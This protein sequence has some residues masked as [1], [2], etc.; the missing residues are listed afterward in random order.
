M[1]DKQIFKVLLTF[2]VV[3]K[4][5]STAVTATT[6]GV[7]TTSGNSTTSTTTP[8]MT[9]PT[10]TNT[11][12]NTTTPTTTTPVIMASNTAVSATTPMMTTVT[13]TITA[14]VTNIT[15]ITN[16][17]AVPTTASTTPVN[18]AT[19]MMTAP[20]N[21]NTTTPTTTT[22]VTTTTAEPVTGLLLTFTSNE[23]F[24][25]DLADSNS[26]AFASRGM[27]V[28]TTL[29]PFYKAAFKSFR[30]LR[31]TSFRSGSIIS[32]I[33]IEFASS[34]VPNTTDIANV[35]I[36]SASNITTFNITTNSVAVSE[37]VASTTTVSATTPM[38]TAVTNAI[39]ANVTNTTPITNTSA[40]PTTA[41]TTPINTA[42]PMNTTNTT[43]TTT[44]PTTTTPVTIT[45]AE[46]V[47]EVK[48]TF[49]SNE[50]FT[51][52]LANSTSTAFINR[53]ML[54]EKTLTPFYIQ[55]LNSFRSLTVILFRSGSIINEMNIGF[56]SSGV[57][58]ITDIGNVL[59]NAA[60]NIT[61]FNIDPTSVVVNG[62]KVNSG[63][64]HKSSLLTASCMVLLSWLMS[65][66]Q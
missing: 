39:T 29:T 22:P 6:T 21:T 16:T 63:V 65:G 3:I 46:P 8:M 40:V 61:A 58:N 62:T 48:L 66:H 2:I 47:T 25:Q 45:T 12:T 17:S 53:K 31:V 36:N 7:S 51:Q 32:D 19:P 33:R 28:Q 57:P 60:S 23:N 26:P 49:T 43:T 44:T 24:T 38:M 41:S 27:L 52:D 15:P 50:T 30:S 56:P 54:I 35:L 20:T 1:G 55:R 5:V 14:N 4:L 34:A 10:N 42:T 64:I 13:N 9:A 37:I 11:N 59:I 18:T